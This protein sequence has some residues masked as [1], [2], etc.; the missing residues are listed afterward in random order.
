MSGTKILIHVEPQLDFNARI[1]IDP[2]P[3]DIEPFL[4]LCLPVC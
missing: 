4:A 1:D 2:G 3:I